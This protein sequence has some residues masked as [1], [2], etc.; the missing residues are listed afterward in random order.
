MH[1]TRILKVTCNAFQK[2][3]NNSFFGPFGWFFLLTR[4]RI[5]EVY[6]ICEKYPCKKNVKFSIETY[7]FIFSIIA[8]LPKVLM[9]N[10]IC[11][12]KITTTIWIIIIWI[13][14][15]LTLKLSPCRF[16]IWVHLESNKPKRVLNHKQNYR[17]IYLCFSN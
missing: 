15:I 13:I 5:C 3:Y 2:C 1:G 12:W 14:Q 7:L 6:V 11:M 4:L 9:H 16:R 8:F 17:N 10:Y